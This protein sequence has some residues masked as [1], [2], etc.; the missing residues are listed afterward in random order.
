M[1]TLEQIISE[2]RL[3]IDAFIRANVGK[4]W[5]VIET[6]IEAIASRLLAPYGDAGSIQRFLT[7]APEIWE[8]ELPGDSADFD[9]LRNLA[10]F[11][12]WMHVDACIGAET[13]DLWQIDDGSEADA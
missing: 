10:Q 11:G 9:T 12:V 13:R 7:E 2:G 8:R 1:K 3:E 5:D 4:G 6:E